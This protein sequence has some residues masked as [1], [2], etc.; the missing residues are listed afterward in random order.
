M[1]PGL[2]FLAW[3]VPA[4]AI[5]LLTWRWLAAVD[6]GPS[7]LGGVM[8]LLAW[9]L[10]AAAAWDGGEHWVPAWSFPA[11][12]VLTL[13]FPLVLTALMWWVAG[14]G[15]MERRGASE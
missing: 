10:L 13:G 15:R 9:G 6:A 5:F 12:I 8:V 14:H 7:M 3:S 2:A 4:G 1:G 11:L